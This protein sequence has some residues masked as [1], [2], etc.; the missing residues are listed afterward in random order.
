MKIKLK[1]YYCSIE[2]GEISNPFQGI[3]IGSFVIVDKKVYSIYQQIF[4]QQ[5]HYFILSACEGNKELGKVEEIISWL[6][7]HNAQRSSWLVGVG[8]GIITDITAWI[9]SNYMRGCHLALIPTT[10]TG[11]IDAAVGGKTALNFAGCKNLIGSFYPAERIIY[12]H[13]FLKTLEEKELFSG[14]G[15]LIKTAL[16]CGGEVLGRLYLLSNVW[17]NEL[18]YFINEAVKYK[19][20]VCQQDLK[21]QGKRMLLNLGHTFAH[22]IESASEFTVEHGRA[23]AVGI[24]CAAELSYDRDYI[25]L[26]RKKKIQNLLENILPYEYLILPQGVKDNI[27]NKGESY[28]LHDKKNNGQPR[29]ILFNGEEGFVIKNN[30]FWNEIEKYL[31]Y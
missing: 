16:L 14:A 20:K 25:K 5:Y 11:M 23:V 3:P 8:G 2:E 26:E 1:D 4:D 31:V 9:A 18:E 10:L 19:L 21:D 6:L 24:A 27:I 15:E 29:L 13:G 7:S 22:V 12:I 28:Y 17:Q 30:I